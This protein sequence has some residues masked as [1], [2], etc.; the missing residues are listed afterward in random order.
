MHCFRST[1]DRVDETPIVEEVG[2]LLEADATLGDEAG[3]GLV[4]VVV[5]MLVLADVVVTGAAVVVVVSFAFCACAKRNIG[6]GVVAA[7]VDGEGVLILYFVTVA[8]ALIS[9]TDNLA[10]CMSG[11][12]DSCSD[13]DPSEFFNRLAPDN[14]CCCL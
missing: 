9:A 7:A 4:V 3:G 12:E 5:T 11:K 8:S 10:H 1:T 14:D 6:D 2:E 13:E